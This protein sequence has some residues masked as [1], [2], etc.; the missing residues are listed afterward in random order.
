MND[1]K[2]S[3]WL[4]W[5]ALNFDNECNCKKEAIFKE[6]QR[7]IGLGIPEEN[8]KQMILRNNK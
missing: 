6:I 1:D 5:I 3:M 2:L 8:I 4:S 7:M